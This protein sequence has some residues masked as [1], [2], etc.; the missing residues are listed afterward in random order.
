MASLATKLAKEGIPLPFG[1]QLWASNWPTG[2]APLHGLIIHLIPSV[3]TLLIIHEDTLMELR[4]K[5]IVILGPPMNVV[6]PFVLDVQGY[7]TQII[8]FFVVIVCL[9]PLPFSCMNT[10]A[11]TVLDALEETRCLQAIQGYINFASGETWVIARCF[12]LVALCSLL[13]RD[14]SVP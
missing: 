8:S 10:V 13:P 4:M 12:N 1:N 6:Y 14:D 2:K 5:V 9:L 7:P 11:G 3:G